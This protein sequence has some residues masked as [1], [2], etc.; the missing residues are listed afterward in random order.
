MNVDACGPP[1]ATAVPKPATTISIA[2]AALSPWCCAVRVDAI[3][4][5][6]EKVVCLSTVVLCPTAPT[7]G[8]IEVIPSGRMALGPKEEE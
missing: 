7:H 8:E 4:L 2:P 1:R 6:V 5:R 3:P